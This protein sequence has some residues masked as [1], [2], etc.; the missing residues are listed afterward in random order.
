[1]YFK[2]ANIEPTKKSLIRHEDAKILSFKKQADNRYFPRPRDVPMGLRALVAI[3]INYYNICF[4]LSTLI[5]K[6]LVKNENLLFIIS[7]SSPDS[8]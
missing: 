3:L 6:T 4:A 5:S 7:Y 8:M 1:M 2:N